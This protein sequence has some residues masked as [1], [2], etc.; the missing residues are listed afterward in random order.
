MTRK[1]RFSLIGSALCV[2]AALVAAISMVGQQA[3]LPQ[4]LILFFSGFGAGATLTSSLRT[5]RDGA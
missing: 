1:Q 5:R 4:I 2:F 3:R